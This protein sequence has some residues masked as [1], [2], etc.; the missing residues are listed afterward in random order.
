MTKRMVMDVESV[1]LHGEAFAVGYVVTDEFGGE[2]GGAMYG[3]SPDSARGTAQNR[4]WVAENVPSVA[5]GC[6]SPAEV[7]AKFWEDFKFWH[8]E[9]DLEVWADCGWPV[10]A[11]FLIACIEEDHRWREWSG[12]FPLHEVASVLLAAGMEPLKTYDRMRDELPV[13]DPLKDAR[14]SAR[15]L[16]E[17]FKKI[18]G[19]K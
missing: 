11:R 19:T 14:Q 6:S 16:T 10:E 12:P 17:A 15:L 3:C 8:E 13:H 7:R 1:G 18:G 2:V 4:A 9:G 5:G